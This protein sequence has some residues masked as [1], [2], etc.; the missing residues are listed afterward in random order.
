MCKCCSRICSC[1]PLERQWGGHTKDPVQAGRAAVPGS[2]AGSMVGVPRIPGG[3]GVQHVWV[4]RSMMHI[5]GT[6][7]QNMLERAI[8]ALPS[9]GRK[10]VTR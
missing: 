4:H 9:C 7:T 2:G 5:V 8:S 6:C 10:A 3:R 1:M